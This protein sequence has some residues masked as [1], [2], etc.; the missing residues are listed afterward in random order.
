MRLACCYYNF[1][2]F[3]EVCHVLFK[4]SFNL[5][6]RWLIMQLEV[7]EHGLHARVESLW[8]FPTGN[9]IE[10]NS[11]FMQWLWTLRLSLVEKERAFPFSTSQ[12]I[13]VQTQ[14]QYQ[15]HSQNCVGKTTVLYHPSSPPQNGLGGKV[16][17]EKTQHV[18]DLWE[19]TVIFLI[20]CYSH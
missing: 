10:T 9:Y 5:T 13:G 16:E 1:Y 7:L 8:T 6:Y 19:L 2:G 18:W 20:V 11:C 17:L 3:E 4:E 15:N 12:T 14:T